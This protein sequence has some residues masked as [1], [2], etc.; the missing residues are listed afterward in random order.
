MNIPPLNTAT[1]HAILSG[2]LPDNTV[3]ALVLQSLGFRYDET[4]QTWDPSGADPAW[5]GEAGI[6]HVIENRSDSVKLTRSIASENK[7]LL[8]EVLGFQGYKIT[9]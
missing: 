4:C 7:Q 8:K 9:N 2:E 3:N 5:Q 6:P 1:I